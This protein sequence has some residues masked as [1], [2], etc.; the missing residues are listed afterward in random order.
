MRNPG[1]NLKSKVSGKP[2]LTFWSENYGIGK[3]HIN[4]QKAKL[5]IFRPLFFIS[6]AK[7]AIVKLDDNNLKIER[8]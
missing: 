3:H 1:K 4:I 5:L 7:Y 6:M 2:F 8:L